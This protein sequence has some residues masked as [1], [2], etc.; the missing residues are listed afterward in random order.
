MKKTKLMVLIVEDIPLIR[1]RLKAMLQ[2]L[3]N[4]KEILEAGNY[5]EAFHHLSKNDTDVML[6][7]LNLP[8]KSG[9]E[10]L[11][12]IGKQHWEL[13]IIVLTN[14][15]NNFYKT[16]CL[17]LGAH[18]FLDKTADFEKVPVIISQLHK[19]N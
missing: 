11:R 2:E 8:G 15:A 9:F 16:L 14:Q 4:V 3:D 1:E 7:D 17:S 5:E 10:I 12:E 19:N 18:Y 13:T 6:L